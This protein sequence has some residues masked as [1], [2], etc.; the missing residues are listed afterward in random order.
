[1]TYSL[2]LRSLQRMSGVHADLRKVALRAIQITKQDFTVIE[3]IRSIERQKQL[4]ASGASKRLNSRHITGH[5]ID[6]AVWRDGKIDWEDDKGEWNKDGYREIGR[7]MFAAAKELKVDIRWGADWNS[8]GKTSDE[9]FLDWVHF[10][11]TDKS[12]PA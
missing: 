3:G 8:N 9:R 10:E 4:V 5:A 6:L 11:L 2:G 12:Y 7:A 1:M